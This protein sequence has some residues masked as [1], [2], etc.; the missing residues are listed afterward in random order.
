MLF[1]AE[2]FITRPSSVGPYY[3]NSAVRLSVRLSVPFVPMLIIR[4]S[5][6]FY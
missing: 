5:N 6:R 3:G 1:L 4:D 2:L